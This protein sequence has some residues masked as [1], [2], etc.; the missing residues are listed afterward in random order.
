MK[1]KDV[2][3][4]GIRI[5]RLIYNNCTEKNVRWWPSKS[6]NHKPN[7]FV[8]FRRIYR[9]SMLDSILSVY[10]TAKAKC[11]EHRA[12]TGHTTNFIA[13]LGHFSKTYE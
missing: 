5:K 1:L 2:I 4:R 9:A 11:N 6:Q 12:I 10:C 8:Y 13:K 3:K 7:V